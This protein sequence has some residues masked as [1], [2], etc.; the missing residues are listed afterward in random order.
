[1]GSPNDVREPALAGWTP[2]QPVGVPPLLQWPPRPG[3]ILRY[4][5][6]FPGFYFPWIALFALIALA[7]CAALQAMGSDLS[8]LSPGWIALVLGFNTLVAAGFYGAWHH[9]LYGRR[10]QGVRFKYNPRWQ[11]SEDKNFLFGRPTASNMFWTLGSGV[12]IWSAYAVLTL[13]AQA[14]G[15]A[16]LTSWSHSP[17]YCAFLMLILPFFHAVHF[18]V[19]HRAIHWAPLYNTVHY[20]HHRNVN[21]SPW[22]GLAM[23]PVEHLIYFSGALL[24][25]LIPST[26]LHVLF[27]TTVVGLAPVQGHSGFGKVVIGQYSLDNDNYYHYLHHKFFKVNYGDSL[28]IPL[29]KLFGSFHDGT[30]RFPVKRGRQADSE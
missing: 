18:Y 28:L 19:F 20:L 5:A 26:P 22:S 16:P 24:L 4:L 17:I 13:W 9:Q 2:E 8:R 25:W 14:R 1:M 23:H 21:P 10:A 7:L 30:R 6:G 12:P 3:K 15:I 27:F 29:D 11:A